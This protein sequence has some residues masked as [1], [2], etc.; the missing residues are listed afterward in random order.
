MN[1]IKWKQ[2]KKYEF[3]ESITLLKWNLSLKIFLTPIMATLKSNIWHLIL[4]ILMNTN[5]S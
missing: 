1:Q 3:M 5:F 2:L 4:T